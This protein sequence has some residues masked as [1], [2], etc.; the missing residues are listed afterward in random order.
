MVEAVGKGEGRVCM[1]GIVGMGNLPMGVLGWGSHCREQHQRGTR[2]GE[3]AS[4]SPELH[5]CG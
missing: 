1:G 2:V 4:G 3:N 5:K